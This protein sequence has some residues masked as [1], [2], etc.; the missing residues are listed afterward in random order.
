[1]HVVHVCT[2][3]VSMTTASAMTLGAV[4][5]DF[6][7]W[8]AVH[9]VAVSNSGRILRCFL[10]IITLSTNLASDIE[11]RSYR[12]C[13]GNNNMRCKGM[14][15][16]KKGNQQREQIGKTANSFSQDLFDF[17]PK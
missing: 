11:D 15:V 8:F 14:G 4:K 6:H 9:Q 7:M 16:Q 1:M 17:A 13:K 12:P 5:P 2:R 10:T 3:P